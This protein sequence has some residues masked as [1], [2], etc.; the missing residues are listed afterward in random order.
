MKPM[1]A[2]SFLVI[3]AALLQVASYAAPRADDPQ[4]SPSATTQA[5][6]SDQSSTTTTAKIKAEMA[7]QQLPSL[8]L[9]NVDT[10]ASG[11]VS[12]SGSALSQDDIDKTVSIARTTPG[13]TQV[14]NSLT[15]KAGD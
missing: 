1:F 10:D 5:A 14:N 15:V 8:S 3:G 6:A 2:L 7:A 4:A 13:V 12:L 9:I 11:V